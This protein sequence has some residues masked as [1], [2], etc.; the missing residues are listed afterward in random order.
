VTTIDPDK[1]AHV[2]EEMGFW[3]SE[4]DGHSLSEEWVTTEDE[5]EA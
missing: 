2:Y 1:A 3:G 5:S 4:T